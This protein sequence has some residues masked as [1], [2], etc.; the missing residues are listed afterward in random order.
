MKK[1]MVGDVP[2]N[3]LGMLADLLHKIQHGIITVQELARFLKRENPFKTPS[4]H[5]V[6]LEWEKF[7]KKI[8]NITID[9][10]NVR[11][12]EKR[13]SFNW[14]LIM[15][16]GLTA[17]KLYDKCEELFRSWKWT[18]K[19]LDEILDQTK[20][21]RNPANG[22][23][24][25]WLRDRV[26]ADEELKNKS[27]NDLQQSD[28]Q[29]ITLEERLL[30]ELFFYWKTKK[31]LDVISWTL[32]SGSRYRDGCV[33]GVGWRG[34]CGGLDVGGCDPDRAPGSLRSREAV[35]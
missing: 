20:S 25:I 29:G 16:P 30:L 10:S 15:I 6:V 14:L 26:E 11:I 1:Q 4:Y 9:L 3:L 21:A 34:Y 5:R 12:P 19:S 32:C 31:H 2:G 24:A 17:Q 35:S 22:T 13:D 28:T 7:Y 18:G 8:F 23:Y 33:P 27:A